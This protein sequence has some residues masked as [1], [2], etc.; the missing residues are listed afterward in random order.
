V[1]IIDR[2][3]RQS[4]DQYGLAIIEVT[5]RCTEDE[6]DDIEANCTRRYEMVPIPN[7]SGAVLKSL[8]GT[9]P[10]KLE[11]EPPTFGGRKYECVKV[12]AYVNPFAYLQD[13]GSYD[14]HYITTYYVRYQEVG[15]TS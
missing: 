14:G 3:Y 9:Q 4:R 15:G 11:V 10:V 2:K 12:D 1:S 8:D 7:A 6:I 13:G 5:G